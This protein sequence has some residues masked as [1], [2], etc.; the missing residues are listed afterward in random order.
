VSVVIE[1][2][3]V[4]QGVHQGFVGKTDLIVQGLADCIPGGLSAG[5]ASKRSARCIPGGLSAGLASE[6]SARCIPGGLSAGFT[7]ERSAR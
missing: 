6:R 5:A 1:T 4:P 2:A 3:E 7:R